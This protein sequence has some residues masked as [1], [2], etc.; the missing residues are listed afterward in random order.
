[1]GCRCLTDETEQ[2]ESRSLADFL[3]NISFA[4]SA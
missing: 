2:S 1:V 3:H 4:K